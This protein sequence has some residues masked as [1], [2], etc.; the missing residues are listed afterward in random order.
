MVLGG[1]RSFLLLVTGLWIKRTQNCDGMLANSNVAPET[2]VNHSQVS[3][4]LK[5]LYIERTNEN[6]GCGVL[7]SIF[8]AGVKNRQT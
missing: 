2:G 4:A 5:P 3:V 7:Y 8:C 6:A 1:C